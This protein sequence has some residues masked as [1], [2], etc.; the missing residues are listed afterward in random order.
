MLTSDCHCKTLDQMANGYVRGEACIAMYLAPPG[1]ICISAIRLQ[2]TFVNQD[3]RSSS[4][5]AP[6]GPSQ[7]QVCLYDSP[8]FAF[9]RTATQHHWM[10]LSGSKLHIAIVKRRCSQVL[11]LVNRT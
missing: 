5:T 10:V 9:L 6:N 11:C 7:Q 1:S 4:L 2:S 8:C 3:G